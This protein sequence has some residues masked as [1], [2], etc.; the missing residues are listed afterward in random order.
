MLGMFDYLKYGISF[1]LAF[2]GIKMLIAAAGYHV[3]IAVSLGVILLSLS[4]AV[5]MSLAVA[6]N[7]T[8]DI[9]M[10]VGFL[11]ISS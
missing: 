5:L 11:R 4:L 9:L 3:P 7:Q 8:V 10:M 6:S 2:I 1:I